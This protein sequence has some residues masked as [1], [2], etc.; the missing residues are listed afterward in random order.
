MLAGGHSLMRADIRVAL[1]SAT[2]VC[3]VGEAS[4][5]NEVQHLV[6][7]ISLG[8]LYVDV[9]RS[10]Y[11]R[12]ETV[13]RIKFGRDKCLIRGFVGQKQHIEKRDSPP[14]GSVC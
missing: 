11:F 12:L 8:R 2:D 5:G 7:G 14:G 13:F 9:D 6:E 1:P 3:V 10:F 4:N